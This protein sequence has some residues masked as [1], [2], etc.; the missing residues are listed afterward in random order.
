MRS[1]P[2]RLITALLLSLVGGAASAAPAAS[3]A[4][5]TAITIG[6]AAAPASADPYFHDVGPDNALARMI[7]GALAR[8]DAKL[9]LHPDLATGWTLK[10][11]RSWTFALRPGVS[12]ADGSPFTANDVVFSLCR[13]RA[14]VGPTHSFTAVPKEIDR[15]DVPDPHTITLHTTVPDPLLATRL[16][17][18]AIISAHSA[19][20]GQVRFDDARDCGVPDMPPSSAFDDLRMANG[21]GPYRLARY[22]SG[23]TIVLARNPH[24]PGAPARW[25]RV[26]LKPVPATGARVAGLLSGDFDLIENPDAQDLP[27]MKARG[28]IAWT[29]TPSDRIIFLQPDIGREISPLATEADGKNPLRDPRVRQA[30]SLAIDRAAIAKRL[31]DGMAV[32]AN[33]YLPPG[34]FGAVPDAPKLKYDPAA[35]RALLAQA[36]HANDIH[37]TLSATKDRYINDA[38]VAQALGQYLARIGIHTTVDAMTQTTFFPQRAKRSFSL[39][40]GGW[41]Y[42]TGEASDLLRNFVV[43]TLPDRG[44]GGSNYG[45]Y[46]SDDFDS[47]FLPAIEDMN[48]AERARQLIAATRIAL[49]DNALIPLYWET[50]IWAY[51]SRYTYAGRIDQ[52]TDPD[53]LR[54]TGD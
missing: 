31:L 17:G 34:L 30:I 44:L 54:P 11:D 29:V 6:L 45:G 2:H 41:G 50:T 19:G 25:D 35:A 27:A 20:V 22:T 13:A 12:F 49:H 9:A 47:I 23:D 46:H 36:G 51:K 16:A 43:S 7:F 24:H 26:I 18:F 52:L 39:A 10:G 3:P 33:Q 48:D 1:A 28:G 14:G 38:A 53:A 8:T 21:T 4:A 15:I 40:L 37:L 42:G 32:P 5:P